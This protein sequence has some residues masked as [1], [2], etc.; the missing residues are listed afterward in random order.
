M[1]KKVT[2]TSCSLHRKKAKKKKAKKIATNKKPISLHFT[3]GEKKNTKSK[4]VI[5]QQKTQ[6]QSSIFCVCLESERATK[7]FIVLKTR[8]YNKKKKFRQTKL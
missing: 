6:P 2:Y 7:Y 8:T 3:P 4:K 1:Y 5:R